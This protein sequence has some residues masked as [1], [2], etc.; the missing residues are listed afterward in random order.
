MSQEGSTFT[1]VEHNGFTIS[2][3]FETEDGMKAALTPPEAGK[4]AETVSVDDQRRM[5]GDDGRFRGPVKPIKDAKPAEKEAEPTA[6]KVEAK[7]EKQEKPGVKPDKGAPDADEIAEAKAHEEEK[8]QQAQ[9]RIRVQEALRQAAQERKEREA[10]ATEAARLR[11]EVEA[12]RS[13]RTAEVPRG[14]VQKQE[15]VRASDGKPQPEHFTTVAEYLDARDEWNRNRWS[16]EARAQEESKRIQ[17]YYVDSATKLAKAVQDAGLS[18]DDFSPEVTKLEPSLMPLARGE[19]PETKH[20][21][22]DALLAHPQDVPA[23]LKHFT[24]HPEEL[25]GLSKM[26]PLTAMHALGIITEKLRTATSANSVHQE[27]YKPEA[28]KPVRAVAGKPHTAESG[29]DD[30]MNLDSDAFFAKRMREGKLRLR[31]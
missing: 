14:T 9:S 12:L 31:R 23:L 6:E 27:P 26:H 25:D 29:P 19:K 30:E 7:A 16:N 2:S 11:A 18:S 13:G 17:E 5:R 28:F 22:T 1:T 21:I 4:A 24:A 8:Q 10:A 15:S 20:F 3:N